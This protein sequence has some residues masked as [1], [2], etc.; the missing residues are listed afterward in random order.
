M[1]VI[2]SKIKIICPS[3][4]KEYF[5]IEESYPMRDK[6]KLHCKEC[7]YLLKEWNAS[8]TYSLEPVLNKEEKT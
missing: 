5:L 2:T 3:C 8:V 7:G 4:R 6:D 1:L